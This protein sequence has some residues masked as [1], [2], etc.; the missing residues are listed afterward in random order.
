MI[1]TIEEAE[2]YHEKELQKVAHFLTHKE[3][4]ELSLPN[5]KSCEFQKWLD[6]YAEVI[7]E[8][9]G[10]DSYKNIEIMHTFWHTEYK[11]LYETLYDTQKN[12]FFTILFGNRR[13]LDD[14]ELK[15]AQHH[16]E[17]LKEITNNLLKALN[18]LKTKVENMKEGLKL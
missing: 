5:K 9:L 6:R 4:S 11:K 1:E 14:R 10:E 15:Q 8:V 17:E 12:R 3:S 18:T 16:Y 13:T 2:Q 7:A